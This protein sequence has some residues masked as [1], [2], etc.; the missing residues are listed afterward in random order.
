MAD[1]IT[2]YEGCEQQQSD[3]GA[4]TMRERL[5]SQFLFRLRTRSDLISHN[6]AEDWSSEFCSKNVSVF[7]KDVKDNPWKEAT[8]EW[9]TGNTSQNFY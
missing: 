7:Y 4:H 2:E 8:L 6:T 3:G 5:M 9:R 1:L